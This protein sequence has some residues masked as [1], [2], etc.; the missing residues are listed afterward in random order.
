[1][2]VEQIKHMRHQHHHRADYHHSRIHRRD[3]RR[4]G[5][6]AALLLIVLAAAAFLIGRW[7]DQTFASSAGS[8]TYGD[9]PE[10]INYNG[11]L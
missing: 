5:I 10:A 8:Y 1:M 6:A 11:V 4:A 3:A 2:G 9:H 7:E